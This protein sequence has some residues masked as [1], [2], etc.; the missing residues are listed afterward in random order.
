MNFKLTLV[1]PFLLAACGDDVH[2][3]EVTEVIEVTETITQYVEVPVEIREDVIDVIDPCGAEAPFDEVLL[4]L[5]DGSL[6][7]FFQQGNNRFLAN[8]PP[9]DYVTT[10]GT[11]CRFTVTEDLEVLDGI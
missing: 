7:A 3:T 9:G 8:I 2:L 4:R 11:N 6:V 10:D 5:A 1:L